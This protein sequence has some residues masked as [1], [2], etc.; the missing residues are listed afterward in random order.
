MEHSSSGTLMR[1][2]PEQ[3]HA[4]LKSHGAQIE[5]LRL[6]V[7]A[8]AAQADKPA[9]LQGYDAA[10]AVVLAHRQATAQPD[11]FLSILD[12]RLK[13]LRLALQAGTDPA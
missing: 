3:N 9:L 10:C 7:I 4:L 11:D 12:A 8:L 2:T 1:P 5:A 13:A 6:A